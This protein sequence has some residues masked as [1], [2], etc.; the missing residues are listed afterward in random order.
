MIVVPQAFFE[1]KAIQVHLRSGQNCF[2]EKKVYSDNPNN[3]RYVTAHALTMVLS[4]ELILK[5]QGAEAQRIKEGKMVFLPRG[6]YFISDIIPESRPFHAY[7]FF[8]EEELVEEFLKE[9][10]VEAT[11]SKEELA[12]NRIYTIDSDY[13]Y[14]IESVLQLYSRKFDREITALKLKEL[15]YLIGR[16]EE[17]SRFYADLISLGE[18]PKESIQSFMEKNY[19]KPLKVEDYAYLTGRSVSTFHRDF[20]RQFGQSPKSWLMQQ[21]LN[22]AKRRLKDNPQWTITQLAYDAG[23]DNV[24][25]FIKAF[26]MLFQESPKQ[27]QLRLRD[28][29]VF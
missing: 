18:R 28:N 29:W 17:G 20:K 13:Q 2:I 21:R 11:F 19:D 25:Y 9:S 14:F 16:S 15:L 12:G 7:V 24:S 8:F 4:G 26:R 1:S 22:R 3:L 5:R 27:Y 10:S 6:L 23:Y